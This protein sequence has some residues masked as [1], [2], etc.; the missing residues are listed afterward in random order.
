MLGKNIYIF[1]D[2]KFIKET[3]LEVSHISYNFL[4]IFLDLGGF[5]SWRSKWSNQCWDRELFLSLVLEYILTLMLEEG[6]RW[7][8]FFFF[9]LHVLKFGNISRINVSS[10]SKPDLL[11][12]MSAVDAERPDRRIW[13]WKKKRLYPSTHYL[14]SR[15]VASFLVVRIF[16]IIP[17]MHNFSPLQWVRYFATICLEI[18]KSANFLGMQLFRCTKIIFKFLFN[19]FE[20]NEIKCL[21]Q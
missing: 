1:C 10:L 16:L 9:S 12:E 17:S 6:G 11:L 18:S 5:F 2:K 3:L 13:E 4:K 7:F 15:F 19:Y 14:N 20:L 8:F 21:E